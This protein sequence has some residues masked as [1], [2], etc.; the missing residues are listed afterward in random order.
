MEYDAAVRGRHGDG[1]PYELSPAESR[2]LTAWLDA[3]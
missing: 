2:D 1:L 3:V